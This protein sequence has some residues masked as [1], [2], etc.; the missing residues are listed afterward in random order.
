MPLEHCPPEG[1]EAYLW[2]IILLKKGSGTRASEESLLLEVVREA[3]YSEGGG[4]TAADGGGVEV[5]QMLMLVSVVMYRS[6]AQNGR[7][8]REV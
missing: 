2:K 8:G 6:E 4:G 3:G 7:A 5:D 1:E